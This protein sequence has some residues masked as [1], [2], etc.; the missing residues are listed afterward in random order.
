MIKDLI[1]IIIIIFLIYRV[2]EIFD[3]KIKFEGY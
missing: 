3:V 2:E 1:Y